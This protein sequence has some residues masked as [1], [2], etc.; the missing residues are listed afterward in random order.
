[1]CSFSPTHQYSQQ[2][3]V[4]LPAHATYLPTVDST[5]SAPDFTTFRKTNHYA[6]NTTFFETINAA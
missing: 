5:I 2:S 1:L 6:D 3:T 4:Q